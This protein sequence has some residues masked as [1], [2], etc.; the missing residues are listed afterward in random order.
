MGERK[1][2]TITEGLVVGVIGSLFA[3][4]IVG[5]IVTVFD[6][7]GSK[8]TAPAIHGLIAAALIFSMC[9]L[10][11]LVWYTAVRRRPTNEKN[12]QER[13]HSWLHKFNLGVKRDPVEGFH[14]NYV[15]TTNGKR[16]IAV[17]RSIS[18]WSDYLIFAAQLTPDKNDLAITAALTDRQ[19]AKVA[20]LMKLELAR[21]QIGYS[22]FSLNGFPITK[23][24]PITAELNESQFIE[25]VWSMEAIINALYSNAHLVVID[26]DEA[27]ALLKEKFPETD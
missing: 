19:R 21:W 24:I 18:E 27:M 17:G 11:L 3:A 2:W 12:I 23:R 16:Q 1:L 6:H 15:V 9:V 10:A 22:N 20:A 14:F 5:V 26:S 13:V 8:W 7:D 4:A 25:A